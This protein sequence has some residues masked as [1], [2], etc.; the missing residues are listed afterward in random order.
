[1]MIRLNANLVGVALALVWAIGYTLCAIMVA[2]SPQ[3]TNR[4][5]GDLVHIDLSSLARSITLGSYATGVIC[6]SAIAYLYGAGTVWIYNR[7][8]RVSA[9]G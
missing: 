1:M 9:A 6:T 7:L 8:S 3:A 5:L 4:F 2:V